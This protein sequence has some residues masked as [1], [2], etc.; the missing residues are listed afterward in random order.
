MAN[1]AV[2]IVHG[3]GWDPSRPIREQYGRDEYAA[4][5]DG[6][7]DDGFLILGGPVG[8]GSRLCTPSRRLTSTRLGRGWPRTNGLPRACSRSGR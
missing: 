4:F 5:F 1:F 7:V 3:P 2:R 6:L 8:N